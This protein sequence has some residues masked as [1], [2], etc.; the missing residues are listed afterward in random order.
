[1]RQLILPAALLALAAPC[2]AAETP[3]LQLDSLF[4][5]HMILPRDGAVVSGSARPREAVTVTGFGGTWKTKADAAGRFSVTLPKLAAGRTGTL[6]VSSGAARV[7][8]ADVVSGDVFL[9]SGQSNMQMAV[10]RALNADTVIGTS[11]N[12]ELRMATVPVDPQPAPRERLGQPLAWQAASP[13]TV[14]NW[15]ATCYFFGKELQR[16][17]KLPIG[18]VHASLGGS[19]LTAWLSPAASLPDYARQQ[20]L[21]KLYAADPAKASIAFGKEVEHWWQASG[22]PGRP[23]AATAADLASWKPAPD[24]AKNWENWGVP[25]LSSYDGSIWYAATVSLYEFY[26]SRAPMI[27]IIE[28]GTRFGTWK[29]HVGHWMP[30]TRPSTLFL[31]YEDLV[32]NIPLAI[33]RLSDFLDLPVKSQKIPSREQIASSDGRWVRSSGAA[34]LELKGAELDRFMEINGETM[35][36]FG[37]V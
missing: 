5:D 27:K 12:P 37:Y 3:S 1:M 14:G 22:G 13:Q 11:A 9:C 24:V 17:L 19:N 23:W 26:E 15:S 35:T 32:A 4:Q 25:E 31:R 10:N 33:E 28:G 16:K 29:D 8:L 20:E 30:E 21:L 6:A 2:L 7:T 36:K 18:L 34:R